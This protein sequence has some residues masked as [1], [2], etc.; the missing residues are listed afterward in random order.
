MKFL[1]YFLLIPTILF[2]QNN[3][4]E[5]TYS[6]QGFYN[7]NQATLIFNQNQ[8]LYNLILYKNKKKA[9]VKTDDDKNEVLISVN[10]NYDLPDDKGLF[11][12]LKD[13]VILQS[14]YMHTDVD[15]SSFDTIYVKEKSNNIVWDIKE[16]TKKI[17]QFECQKA[18]GSF[19]GR[20][21]TVWFSNEIPV[22][23]GPWKLN[24]LPG[25]IIE[26]VDDEKQFYFKAEKISLYKKIDIQISN[27][28][29]DTY[30][31]PI[32]LNKKQMDLAI[33]Y[34]D[35]LMQK[36]RASLPRGV[37]SKSSKK[38]GSG[39]DESKHIERNY[40]DIK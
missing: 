33:K 38:P 24:G 6:I 3:S 32:E 39:I 14:L 10:T 35:K 19:R 27:F 2:A 4:G 17:E 21:Y 36:I 34:D 13:N 5:I 29:S 18:I 15:S 9:S 30:I 1:Q 31:S 12:D 7:A 22:R 11:F 20:T 16:E 40:D 25:L 23:F 37:T 8:S 28:V 26:A